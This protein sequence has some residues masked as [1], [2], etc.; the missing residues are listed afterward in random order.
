[1]RSAL[2]PLVTYVATSAILFFLLFY[3]AAFPPRQSIALALL[4]AWLFRAVTHAGS[5]P[6]ARFRPYWV[7]ATPNWLQIL[8]DYKLLANQE[9][10]VALQSAMEK[11]SDSENSEAV[12]GFLYTVV[13]HSSDGERML[14]YLDR[15]NGFKSEVNFVEYL[16]P[17]GPQQEVWPK[18][19]E[20]IA[21]LGAFMKW[22][23]DGGY[24]LGIRVEMEWWEKLKPSCPPVLREDIDHPCG[25]VNLTLAILP[26][27][28]FQMYWDPIEF[29]TG[30]HI[31]RLWAGIKEARDRHKW[32]EKKSDWEWKYHEPKALS[33]KYYDVLHDSI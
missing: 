3:L 14:L 25:R 5:K 15:R 12:Q 23:T 20:H 22:G 16:R 4:V 26:Y 1:M 6:P 31:D 2:K 24:D 33:H 27:N 13:Q 11:L 28:E 30:K 29:G 19:L 32:L 9:E 7:R 21:G 18:S 10:W 8:S 17:F